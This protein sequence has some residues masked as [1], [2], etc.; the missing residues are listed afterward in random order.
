V[1]GIAVKR[2]TFKISEAM[3]D[4]IIVV[5]ALR[6]RSTVAGRRFVVHDV[7]MISGV[8]GRLFKRRRFTTP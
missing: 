4:D 3:L 1:G 7:E 2:G 8:S 5:N 6:T